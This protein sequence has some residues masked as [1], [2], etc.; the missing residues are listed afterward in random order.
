M[1]SATSE[2]GWKTSNFIVDFNVGKGKNLVYLYVKISIL[3]IGGA[4]LIFINTSKCPLIPVIKKWS[5]ALSSLFACSYSI[6]A[7]RILSTVNVNIK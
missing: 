7:V 4:R 3:G 1:T 6:R 5:V 2:V